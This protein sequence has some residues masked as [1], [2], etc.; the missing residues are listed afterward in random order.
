MHETVTVV[1]L[2][3]T[4][5][6]ERRREVGGGERKANK[7]DEGKDKA[8]RQALISVILFLFSSSTTPTH[9]HT[10]FYSIAISSPV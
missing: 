2:T 9:T 4:G 3:S 10:I 6:R 8:L 1:S 5:M 7:G